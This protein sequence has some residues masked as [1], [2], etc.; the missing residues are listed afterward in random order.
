VSAVLAIA[1]SVAVYYLASQSWLKVVVGV[2]AGAVLY[3]AL[4]PMQASARRFEATS[5]S[6][7]AA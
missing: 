5:D 3:L 1:G 7:R 2:A 4:M 6:Q